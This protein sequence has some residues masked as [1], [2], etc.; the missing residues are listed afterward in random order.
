MSSDGREEF[1]KIKRKIKQLSPSSFDAAIKKAVSNG[2]DV[3]QMY[4]AAHNRKT[5]NYCLMRL[6]ID[7]HKD[8]FVETALNNGVECNCNN[9]YGIGNIRH[10]HYAVKTANSEAV[11][12]LLEYGA[13]PNGTDSAGKTP[14][15]YIID[16]VQDLSYNKR[17]NMYNKLIHIIYLL[18][19]YGADFNILKKYAPRCTPLLYLCER[20]CDYK[21]W[22]TFV[23]CGADVNIPGYFT[24]VLKPQFAT[25][26]PLSELCLWWSPRKR[27][28]PEVYQ[29]NLDCLKL[30]LN[31]G[32]R[33]RC[34]IKNPPLKIACG[35]GFTDLICAFIDYGA[36]IRPDDPYL[37]ILPAEKK[38][39][40]IDYIGYTKMCNTVEEHDEALFVR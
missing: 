32:A 25:N 26:T 10:L 17:E 1:L 34:N 14:L 13:D 18:R 5:E 7:S 40:V 3:N 9:C 15:F 24:R 12:T 27:C 36:F 11:E 4:A 35:L 39:E 16:V 30:L 21:L 38:K 22:K 20:C 29:Q 23:D 37:D 33:I 6:A 8:G 31:A 19:E 28:A 2:M